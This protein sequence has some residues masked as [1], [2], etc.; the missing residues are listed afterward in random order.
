[1]CV[2]THQ[3]GNDGTIPRT[4]GSAG[5]RPERR[6]LDLLGPGSLVGGSLERSPGFTRL[7]RV[8]FIVNR[9]TAISRSALAPG[10]WLSPNANAWRLT[11]SIGRLPMQSGF[12]VGI[13]R[14]EPPV[15]RQSISQL[16]GIQTERAS[17][18]ITEEARLPQSAHPPAEDLSVG[19]YCE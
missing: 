4:V 3:R 5:V 13:N 16:F 15:L 12:Q 14:K 2:L 11:K 10:E 7:Q 17:F 19:G 18:S 9:S 8:G 6:T 1:M